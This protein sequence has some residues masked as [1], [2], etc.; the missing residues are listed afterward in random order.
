MS[1][2]AEISSPAMRIG[3]EEFKSSAGSRIVGAKDSEGNDQPQLVVC[4]TRRL[5][6]KEDLLLGLR[7]EMPTASLEKIISHAAFVCFNFELS[8]IL[9]ILHLHTIID[10][11]Q[12]Y[13]HHHICEMSI[14]K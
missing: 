6:T 11:A 4:R 9:L 8:I 14:C 1:T 10:L 13:I 5:H 2:I 12:P 3:V 7:L